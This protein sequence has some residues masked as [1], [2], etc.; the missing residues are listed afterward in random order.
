L[1]D[2]SGFKKILLDNV[3]R[4]TEQEFKKREQVKKKE[5]VGGRGEC[6]EVGNGYSRCLE[7]EGEGGRG[8]RGKRR[9]ERDE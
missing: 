6:Q 9:G 1:L 2:N 7:I 5:Y 4:L 3:H 8:T